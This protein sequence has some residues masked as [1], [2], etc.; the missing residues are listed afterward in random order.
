MVL[1][2]A[3]ALISLFFSRAN[4]HGYMQSPVMRG[5]MWRLP[6]RFPEVRRPANYDDNGLRADGPQIVR[7]DYPNM[8][9][10][11]CGDPYFEPT[12]RKH[13]SGGL[14]GRFPELGAAAIA[15]CFAPGSEIDISIKITAHHKGWFDFRLC[16]PGEGND[17]DES[18]FQNGYHLEKADKTGPIYDL[19]DLGAGDYIMRYKLPEGVVCDGN[20][21][22]ILRWYWETGNTPGIFKEVCLSSA[23]AF[24]F[25]LGIPIFSAP[26]H[27]SKIAIFFSIHIYWISN[28]SFPS[29]LFLF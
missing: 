10:G 7:K 27:Y 21:R 6:N 28:L 17:E 12:P 19:P 18:C 20:S 8:R 2:W 22:C 24:F 4:G 29:S 5:S 25:F 9:Y 3:F 13:E 15:Q 16:V 23:L 1:S 26:K 14:F 11:V